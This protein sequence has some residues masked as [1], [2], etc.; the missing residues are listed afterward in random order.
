MKTLLVVDDNEQNRYMLQALFS[1]HGYAV[2]MDSDGVEAL[3]KAREQL[4][5]L[6]I[7]VFIQKPYA[8]A[9]LLRK[10]REV[11]DKPMQKRGIE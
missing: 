10:V 3:E 2:S 9:A 5:D 7:I 11:L 6:V 4:P 8:P 1:G